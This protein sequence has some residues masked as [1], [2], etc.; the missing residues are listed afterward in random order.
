MMYIHKGTLTV[1]FCTL[2]DNYYIFFDAE[3]I[4]II[5]PRQKHQDGNCTAV[6]LWKKKEKV[7][8]LNS[9]QY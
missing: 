1:L 7:M 8:E 6:Y 4:D 9:M 5:L 2:W 3:I